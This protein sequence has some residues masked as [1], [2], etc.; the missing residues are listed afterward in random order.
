MTSP[1]H[2]R[3]ELV[4]AYLDGEAT[5]EE[6][7]EVER[8]PE[9]VARA[10]VFARVSEQVAGP[11][12]AT[13]PGATLDDMIGRALDEYPLRPARDR[14]FSPIGLRWASA[15]AAVA[16]VFGGL[17]IL[18]ERRGSGEDRAGT[19]SSFEASSAAATTTAGGRGSADGREA[20]A[21]PQA[22]V[23]GAVQSTTTARLSAPVHL[24]AFADDSALLA[25]LNE[26]LKRSAGG[27]AP[28]TG[29]ANPTAVSG[30]AEAAAAT[31]RA[32]VAGRD[33]VVIVVAP[34]QFR[35]IDLATCG[36]RDLR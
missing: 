18:V 36:A 23:P 13:A 27:A 8:D 12:T 9:L 2:T 20:S 15:A 21:A 26:T 3:D 4:S 16:L 31:Y 19:S 34:G 32:T 28:T 10:A 22:A 6:Q 35:V 7:A 25:A 5:P 1:D 29:A 30:C 11:P 14:R 17:A 33:T 24:G